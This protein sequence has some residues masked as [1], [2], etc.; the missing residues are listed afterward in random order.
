MSFTQDELQSLNTIVEQKLSAYHRDLERT[1]DQRLNV[2]KRELE[3]RLI[4]VQQDVVRHLP[5]RLLHQ[6][7]KLREMMVQRFDA[8]QA[9]L[10]Q[11]VSK[12][13][14]EIQK[15]QQ[16]QFERTLKE[17]LAAQLLAVEQ[18]MT[19]RLPE[20]SVDEPSTDE[21]GVFSENDAVEVQAEI[22]WEE[23]VDI[24]GKALDDR[25]TVLDRSL[26]ESVKGLEGYLVSQ[27]Y[28]VRNL[29]VSEQAQPFGGKLTSIQEVLASIEQLERIIESLQVAMTANQALLSS[30]LYHHQQLP[31]ERAHPN[32][33]MPASHA[34]GTGNQLPFPKEHEEEA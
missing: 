24:V 16:E 31:L 12:E 10:I 5:H 2:L 19:Q 11:S 14:Y 28:E 21:N 13:V 6:Q 17:S 3:Q 22:S 7:N 26:Q 25:L 33:P 34:N 4:A 18:L 8:Q 9:Q 29:L 15:Q 32:T 20:L 27:I 23:L 1:F 30:R